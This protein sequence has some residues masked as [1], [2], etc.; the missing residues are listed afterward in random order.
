LLGDENLGALERQLWVADPPARGDMA[1]WGG[2]LAALIDEMPELHR[3]GPYLADVARVEWRMH[4]SATEPDR[5]PDP[6]SFVLLAERDPAELGLR[7]APGASCIESRWP[8]ASIV[9]AHR[10]V[11]TLE[12]AG[13]RLRAGVGETALVW[14]AGFAPQVR[15]AHDGEREFIAAL[16]ESRSLADSLQA[17]PAFDFAAWLAPAAQ[18]QLL[19]GATCF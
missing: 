12:I 7:L 4:R 1:H 13:E 11:A 14:R 18:E 3:A 10:G 17:V 15:M 2:A 8:V 16:Q 9:L 6:A 19:L 5:E